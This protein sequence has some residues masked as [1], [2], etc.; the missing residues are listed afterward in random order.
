[1][2]D[3]KRLNGIIGGQAIDENSTTQKH[4][5]GEI[6]YARDTASTAYGDGV[7]IYCTGLASVAVGECVKIEADTYT[8]KLA[9]ADD[10]GAIGFAMAATV[11]DEYGWFQIKG[12][13]VGLGAASNADNAAQYLT[14]TAGT[15]DDAVVAG[16]RIHNCLSVSAVD[17]PSTGLIE[18]DI[19]YP[20]TDN[21]AD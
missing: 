12:C 1:M 18:L 2:S 9:V 20:H 3:F 10:A 13:A 21:I 7:F 11:A 4:E 16:D 5:L 6:A 19:N 14:A 8:V 17:T 15:I